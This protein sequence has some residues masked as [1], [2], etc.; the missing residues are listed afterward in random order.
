MEALRH[1]A[2][3]VSIQ[4]VHFEPYAHPQQTAFNDTLLDSFLENSLKIIF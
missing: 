3:K 4:N 1:F 2:K